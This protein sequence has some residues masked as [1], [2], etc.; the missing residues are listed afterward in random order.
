MHTTILSTG[1]H[2]RGIQSDYLSHVSL[3]IF[4]VAD[5]NLTMTQ[6]TYEKQAQA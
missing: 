1:N 2:P 4:K 3:L 5:Y 6:A